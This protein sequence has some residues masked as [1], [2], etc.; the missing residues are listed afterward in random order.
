MLVKI[1]D[2]V[3]LRAGKNRYVLL[4]FTKDNWDWISLETLAVGSR[5]DFIQVF[6]R[7]ILEGK[8][9]R[10]TCF[11]LNGEPYTTDELIRFLEDSCEHAIDVA[12]FLRLNLLKSL[13]MSETIDGQKAHH[14]ITSSRGLGTWVD[15]IRSARLAGQTVEAIGCRPLYASDPSLCLMEFNH[16]DVRDTGT[17]LIEK[18]GEYYSIRTVCQP[19]AEAIGVDLSAFGWNSAVRMVAKTV[20]GGSVVKIEDAKLYVIRVISPLTQISLDRC[21]YSSVEA[22]VTCLKMLKKNHDGIF[23]VEEYLFVEGKWTLTRECGQYDLL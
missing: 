8:D 16:G 2:S 9:D 23:S 4:A 14:I 17:Y 15:K 6:S 3:C 12:E 21:A 20:K 13:R 22:A 18:D 1:V 11:K 10:T 19:E 5:R 7:W